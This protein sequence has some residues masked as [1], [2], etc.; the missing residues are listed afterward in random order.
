MP[1][2]L[3][4]L[5]L[6][7]PS[8]PLLLFQQLLLGKSPWLLLLLL[9]HL[10][11]LLFLLLENLLGPLLFL[12]LLGALLLYLLLAPWLLLLLFSFRAERSHF[13][14]SLP[15][16]LFSSLLAPSSSRLLGAFCPAYGGPQL[17]LLLLWRT[18]SL[19]SCRRRVG[20]EGE[21]LKLA[22]PRGG[23]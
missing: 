13:F 16:I 6:P 14:S 18:H 23:V 4:L 7:L 17:L 15:R 8:P 11:R 19:Y 2:L 21:V 1:G 20:R 3:L 5:V 10:L 22:G 12:Q 9:L